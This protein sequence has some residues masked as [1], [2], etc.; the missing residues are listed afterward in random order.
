MNGGLAVWLAD[1]HFLRPAWLLLLPPLAW[2]CW[3]LHRRAGSRDVLARFCD[4]ALLP[5]LTLTLAG[6]ARGRLLPFALGGVLGVLALAGP[7]VERVPQPVYREQAALVVLLDLSRSM[8]AQDV[9][10][11]RLERARYKIRDLLA[12]R[13]RGQTALVVYTDRAFVVTPLTD[14]INTIVS[15]LSVMDPQLMPS[16]GTDAAVAVEEALKLLDQ[17][18]YPRGDLLM[19]TDDVPVAQ[20]ARVSALLQRRDVRLSLL[21]AGTAAGAPVPDADGGFVK[22]AAGRIVVAR[23]DPD[24]LAAVARAGHGHYETLSPDGRDV[25]ALQAFLDARELGEVESAARRQA[26]QWQELGPWLLVPLVLLASLAFRRGLL[27]AALLAVLVAPRPATAFDWWFTPDQA[28]QR[29]F[30]REDFAAAAT[31]YA[32]PTW[33]A[34]AR[35]RAGDY[36]A[37]AR[38]LD[39]HTD[40]ESLY[41]RGNALA[42]QGKLGEALAAYDAALKA[43][44]TLE[45]ARYNKALIEDLLRQQQAQDEQQPDQQQNAGDD[46]QQQQPRSGEQG[47]N[48]NGRQGQAGER[49][50]DMT[51]PQDAGDEASRDEQSDAEQ[52]AQSREAQ[53]RQSGSGAD[54]A[55]RGEADAQPA[56]AD[57]GHRDAAGEREEAIAAEQWL[58]QVP[59]DPGGLWRRKFRY[60]YQRQYG[61]QSG[62]V[63]PW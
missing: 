5:H 57:E 11:S 25:D 23:F 17:A 38:E 2:L 10:P 62:S 51:P 41:N 20:R 32:D 16:Q 24:G 26:E 46:G 12:A 58:R 33:R 54:K 37:A 31:R 53:A 9:V 39:G 48:E 45:D 3:R 14:D 43:A 8:G 35:Y 40:G 21:G 60:Q 42:R 56:D 28:G 15:Q 44:P 59:D 34:A 36:A 29:A 27:A 63:E 30:E 4:A 6:V 1:F 61:G 7:T 22:D 49:E 55:A 50:S 18:G 13:Q 52:G 47:Q 19:V